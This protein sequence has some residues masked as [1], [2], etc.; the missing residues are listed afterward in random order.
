MP[1]AD[2][3]GLLEGG[4]GN[5]ALGCEGGGA[6]RKSDEERRQQPFIG[7][8]LLQ[9]KGKEGRRVRPAGRAMWCG[10]GGGR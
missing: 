3:V 4:E 1:E 7:Y 8:D 2:Q 10:V 6:E 5:D 9:G